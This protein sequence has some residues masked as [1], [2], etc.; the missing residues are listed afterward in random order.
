MVT[1]ALTLLVALINLAGYL[2]SLIPGHSA[3]RW[4]SKF[5][6]R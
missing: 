5:A 3:I 2:F 4:G 1:D 6:L